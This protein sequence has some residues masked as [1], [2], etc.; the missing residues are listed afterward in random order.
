MGENM[1]KNEL[2][3]VANFDDQLSDNAC[4]RPTLNIAWNDFRKNA[5]RLNQAKRLMVILAEKSDLKK[6]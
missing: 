5:R 2:T 1:E 4:W 6:A 3:M